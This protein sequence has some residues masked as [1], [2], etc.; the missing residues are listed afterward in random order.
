MGSAGTRERGRGRPESAS[1]AGEEGACAALAERLS[2]TLGTGVALAARSR[3][4]ELRA[5]RISDAAL[6][7]LLGPAAETFKGLEAEAADLLATCD[8]WAGS[9]AWTWDLNAPAVEVAADTDEESPT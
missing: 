6:A 9:A 7:G 8:R 3:W 1:R 5:A 2:R 4:T